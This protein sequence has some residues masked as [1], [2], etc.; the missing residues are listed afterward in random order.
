MIGDSD[1]SS[2]SVLPLVS[3]SSVS[4]LTLDSRV[5]T[6]QDAGAAECPDDESAEIPAG[7]TVDVI[8][9]A[10]IVLSFSNSIIL[11]IIYAIVCMSIDVDR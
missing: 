8:R 1:D 4:A 2:V 6:G 5:A 11:V 3:D 7:A 10:S 9:W